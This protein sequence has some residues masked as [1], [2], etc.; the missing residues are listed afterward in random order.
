MV[1]T[2]GDIILYG[3]SNISEK[4]DNIIKNFNLKEKYFEIKL[5]ISEAVSNAYIHGNNSDNSKPIY[6][7]WELKE[8]FIRIAVKDCGSGVESSKANKEISEE[9]LLDE[10]G[11]G[12]FII[13]SYADEVKFKGNSIIME[14]YLNGY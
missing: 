11:R 2:N 9:S 5:I 4:L 6:V 1:V 8:N 7:Q 10:C 13:R 3:I 12:L 14:K